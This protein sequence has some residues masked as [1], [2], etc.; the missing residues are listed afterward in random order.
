MADYEGSLLGE[1]CDHVICSLAV[2]KDNGRGGGQIWEGLMTWWM[3]N[4]I[5]EGGMERVWVWDGV[6]RGG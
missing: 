4:N 3:G 5:G 1:R 2:L 6:G